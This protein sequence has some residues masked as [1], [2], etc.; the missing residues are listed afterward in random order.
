M[1]GIVGFIWKGTLV[2]SNMIAMFKKQAITAPPLIVIHT[3]Y[4]VILWIDVAS[5]ES[6]SSNSN[7][8]YYMQHMHNYFRWQPLGLL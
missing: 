7:S 8:G 1:Q 2:N 3:E 6:A 4:T 5:E